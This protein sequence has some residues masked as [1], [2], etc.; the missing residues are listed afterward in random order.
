MRRILDVVRTPV[1]LAGVTLL[2]TSAAI[3]V[4]RT[5][6][7]DRV[8]V[9]HTVTMRNN[10]FVPDRL[11]VSP[12]DT[13][14]FVMASGGPHNVAFWPDSLPTGAAPILGVGVPE[15]IDTLMGP[16]LVSEGARYMVVLGAV[17]AGRYPYYCLPHLGSGMR[18]EIVVSERL[19]LRESQQQKAQESQRGDERVLTARDAK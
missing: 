3:P 7:A 4:G 1:L 11:T 13:V 8:P 15:P 14:T 12:G 10:R 6:V 5:T 2:F 18:A 16:L 9:T 19:R 17:P